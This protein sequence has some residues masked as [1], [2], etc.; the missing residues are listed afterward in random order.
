MSEETNVPEEPVVPEVLKNMPVDK[1]E[2]M[3]EKIAQFIQKNDK[4]VGEAPAAPGPQPQAK[5]QDVLTGKDVKWEEFNLD[6]NVRHL[7]PQARFLNTPQGPKWVVMLDEY[8]STERDFRAYGKEVN[9]PESE[10]KEPLNLGIWLTGMVNGPEQWHVAAVMPTTMG[11]V[12]VLLQR[13]VPHIL[14]DPLPLETKTEVEAPTDPELA[15][16]EDAAL[17]FMRNEGLTPEPLA[18]DDEG[19]EQ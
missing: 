11:R 5:E 17:D 8:M 1:Q 15:R 12:G 19:G 7:Y 18:T 6:F 16:E 10:Q 4:T 14:P 3:K 13:K 9:I 2:R